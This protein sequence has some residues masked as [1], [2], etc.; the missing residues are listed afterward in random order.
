MHPVA[1]AL[2]H[3]GGGLFLRRRTRAPKKAFR[4]HLAG[5]SQTSN[6]RILL[7]SPEKK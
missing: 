5:L 6:H 4:E 7:E 2:M 3:H 1:G